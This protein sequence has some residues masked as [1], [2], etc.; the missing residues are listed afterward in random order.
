MIKTETLFILGAGASAPF[1]YPTNIKLHEDIL[2]REH[3]ETII[4]ALN[5]DDENP[6][7]IRSEFD[8]FLIKFKNAGIYSIDSFLEHRN[9]FEVIGKITIAAHLINHEEDQLLR[10]VDKNWYMYLYN[11]LKDVVFDDFN[12][13]NISFITFNYDRSLE[14]FLFKAIRDTYGKSEHEC[15]KKIKNIPIVHLYGQLDLLPWQGGRGKEYSTQANLIERLRSAPE[16]IQLI[17]NARDVANN[18]KFKEA[19]DLIKKAKRIFF[20]GFSFDETNVERLNIELMR[21]KSILSSAM[22]LEPAKQN[23]VRNYFLGRIQASVNLLP[24]KDDAL[25][26]LQDGLEF[27]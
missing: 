10:V 5:V 23:W 1:K 27:D 17:S 25:S 7:N 8:N 11:R 3:V 13:N 21:N 12:K 20:L 18:E 16:N 4:K 2:S 6:N 26:A 9:E 19:H 14:Q 24:E 15:A 22:G